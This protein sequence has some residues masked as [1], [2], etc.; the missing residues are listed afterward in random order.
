MTIVIDTEIIELL[1]YNRGI[2]SESLVLKCLTCTFSDLVIV[3][4]KFFPSIYLTL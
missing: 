1:E 2:Y 3:E 4:N